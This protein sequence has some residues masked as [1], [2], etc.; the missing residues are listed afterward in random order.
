MPRLLAAVACLLE[1]RVFQGVRLQQLWLAGLVALE[2]VGSF[3]TRDPAGVPLRCTAD[4]QPLGYQGSPLR[5]SLPHGSGMI[6]NRCIY[7][8]LFGFSS[9][10]QGE[11]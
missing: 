3:Q 4:S 9:S 2:R 8:F 6:S 11:G 5:S 7:L 1:G 10:S